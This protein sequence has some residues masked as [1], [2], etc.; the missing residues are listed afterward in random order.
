MLVVNSNSNQLLLIKSIYQDI[1]VIRADPNDYVSRY[2]VSLLS[3][4]QFPEHVRAFNLRAP[5]GWQ[6]AHDFTYASLL[7]LEGDVSALNLINLDEHGL[8]EYRA[9]LAKFIYEKL[10]YIQRRI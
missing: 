1:G 6:F 2:G 10:R 4:L 9:W 3:Y 8:S 7:E 5:S